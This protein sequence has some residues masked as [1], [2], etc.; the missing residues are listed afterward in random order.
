VFPV[1]L[2][3][4]RMSKLLGVMLVNDGKLTSTQLADALIFQEK[5]GGFL[6]EILVSKKYIDNETL[7]E[8]LMK[9]KEIV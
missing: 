9:Q 4:G 1:L 7:H 3:E 6:G 5:F 2:V 8:Y